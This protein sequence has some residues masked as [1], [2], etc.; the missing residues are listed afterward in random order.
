MRF[1]Q[2]NNIILHWIY[3][4][5]KQ[6]L[7]LDSRNLLDIFPGE[8]M[9]FFWEMGNSVVGFIRISVFGFWIYFLWIIPEND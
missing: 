1:P 5:K 9:S 2:V 7:V 4:N 8:F 3:L 6:M